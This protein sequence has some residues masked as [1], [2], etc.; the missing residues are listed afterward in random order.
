MQSLDVVATGQK[1]GRQ[2]RRAIQCAKIGHKLPKDLDEP[3][4]SLRVSPIVAKILGMSP[5]R[6]IFGEPVSGLGQDRFGDQAVVAA[7]QDR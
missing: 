3:A 6:C 5:V 4:K 7:A 2:R 1:V